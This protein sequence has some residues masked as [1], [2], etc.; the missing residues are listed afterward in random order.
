[1]PMPRLSRSVFFSKRAAIEGEEVIAE[2]VKSSQINIL[3]HYK[4]VL[5][6]LIS[7]KN[8]YFKEKGPSVFNQAELKRMN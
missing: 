4:R 3:C 5:F 1:M 8:I 7:G 2:V 6:N